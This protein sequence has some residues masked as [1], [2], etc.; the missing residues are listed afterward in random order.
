[1]LACATAL[2]V[3]G[4]SNSVD[5]SALKKT[6]TALDNTSVGDVPIFSGPWASD[7]TSEYTNA[8][9]SDFV[10]EILRDE[11]IT[12]QELAEVRDRN[13]RCLSAHGFTAIRFHD[14]GTQE[15]TAPIDADSDVVNKKATQCSDESGDISV[16][17]LYSW[18]RRNP[19]NLDEHTIMATC[20]VRKG[21]VDPSYTA[22]DYARDLPEQSFP[23]T[24]PARGE[25]MFRECH[26][27]PLER[28]K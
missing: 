12:D 21:I 28:F 11:K 3:A 6:T 22:Q 1:M 10:R 7:F 4:C 19:E 27:D 9:N 5:T 25:T 2:A 14:D 26:A 8:N 23:Y 16:G 17:A 24:D 13:R 18:M 20:L 15:L